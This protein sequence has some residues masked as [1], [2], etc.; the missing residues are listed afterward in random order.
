MGKAL[1]DFGLQTAQS[2]VGAG[3]GMV[4]RGWEDRQQLKQQK[5]LQALEIG[6]QKEMTDYNYG[7]QMQMW[8][9]TNY[10][11]QM[12]ELKSA[13]LNP[14]LMYGMGG[15]G[16]VTTGG[17]GGG[18]VSGATAKGGGGEAQA[19]AATV[20]QLGLM[21]AQKENIEADTANKKAEIPVKGATA[22]GLGYD[23]RLKAGTLDDRIET[24]NSEMLIAEQKLI[25]EQTQT[26]LDRATVMQKADKL[27]AEAAGEILKNTLMEVQKLNVEQGT[28]ESKERIKQME[29][30][31][32]KWKTEMAQT[33]AG[34][35]RQERELSLKQF[36]SEIKA[37]FPGMGQALGKVINSSIEGLT[38]LITGKPASAPYKAPNV[39]KQ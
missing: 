2:V 35:D 25:Q 33:W 19:M 9:D 24:I 3:L 28:A 1:A 15:G 37:N 21:R 31:I 17:G 7:K 13:G 32:S 6:G 39:K 27:K 11:A 14:G 38:R 12:G 36:E 5:K 23:N 8:K 20:A 10:G 18:N 34:L 26:G 30:Q 4:M 29:A 16:G 22:E